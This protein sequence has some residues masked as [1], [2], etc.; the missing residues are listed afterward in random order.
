MF[1]NKNKKDKNKDVETQVE[2][3]PA[4]EETIPEPEAA[5]VVETSPEP[6]VP[7]EEKQGWL[8]RMTSGLSKSTN[9]ITTGL[10]D[11]VTKRKLDDAALEELEE[12]LITADLGPNTAAAIIAEFSKTRFGKEADGTEIREALAEIMADMLS[13][14]A[15]PLTI[16]KP[17]DGPYVML[18]CGVNGAGKTTTIGKMA[19]QMIKQDGHNVMIAAGDTF[20]AAA[21]EQLQEWAKRS[22][23]LFHAKETNADAASV[24][25]EAYTKAKEQGVDVLIVD[26]AGR[27]Q[28]KK[29]LMEELQKIIRVLQ[30]QDETVPHTTLLVLDATTGQNAFS[31]VDIFKDMMNVTGLIVTK[32]DGSAKGGVLI[33]LANQFGLPV[34]AIGVGESIADL[35]TF[36]ANE[37]AKSLMG[38]S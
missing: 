4:V 12:M 20:R 15:Q 13:P 3:A 33:G 24:A 1:W 35:Q 36:D 18:V 21:V 19:D 5:P 29:G 10:S 28:N 2:E 25:F 34:H 8:T 31:Q 32:L 6:E 14:V 16:T 38:I 7:A 27:L 11:F 9:K 30:K 17:A 22:G 23:A 37:Y 26:T